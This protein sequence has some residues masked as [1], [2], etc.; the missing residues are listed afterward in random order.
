M[1][2]QKKGQN[3]GV[4]S[5]SL[6]REN[7]E[8]MHESCTSSVPSPPSCHIDT[9]FLRFSEYPGL[10]LSS[11]LS[12]GW[13]LWRLIMCGTSTVLFFVLLQA[14]QWIFNEFSWL[15]KKITHKRQPS[16]CSSPRSGVQDNLKH[17]TVHASY[18]ILTHVWGRIRAMFPHNQRRKQRNSKSNSMTF[19]M[20]MMRESWLILSNYITSWKQN[21]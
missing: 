16:S 20:Q 21:I 2:P 12:I 10:T 9:S 14:H 17:N 6:T 4:P 13:N 7:M 11:E 3:C 19:L 5:Y 18:W 15:K 8:R 1:T